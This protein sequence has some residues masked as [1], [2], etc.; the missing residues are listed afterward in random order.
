MKQLAHIAGSRGV[1]TREAGSSRIHHTAVPPTLPIGCLC[2]VNPQASGD[3]QRR[4]SRP[5]EVW[6][7][8]CFLPVLGKQCLIFPKGNFLANRRK[9]KP[10]FYKHIAAQE[11]LESRPA[12]LTLTHFQPSSVLPAQILENHSQNL[13]L[14]PS[15]L[16][17]VLNKHAL[18][19]NQ[20]LN[21]VC[22]H[23]LAW[24]GPD[25]FLN[26]I[27]QAF[28]GGDVDERGLWRQEVRVQVASYCWQSI[29][30]YLSCLSLN[31]QFLPSK[32]R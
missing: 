23:F 24:K 9:T 13:L 4:L 3:S 14:T 18:S 19:L 28:L 22:P 11:I 20:K 12:Q 10:I 15:C 30:P 21:W 32:I 27:F 29:W 31:H 7:H 8:S 6:G 16:D 25:V 1:S 2:R 17:W 5:A 26:I